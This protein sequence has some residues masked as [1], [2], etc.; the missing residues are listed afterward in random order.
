[1]ENII[2]SLGGDELEKSLM[3]SALVFGFNKEAHQNRPQLLRHAI[4]SIV[5]SLGITD[6]EKIRKEFKVRFNKTVAIE[7]IQKHLK[8]LVK[9]KYLTKKGDNYELAS[10]KRS[11]LKATEDALSASTARL[12]DEIYARSTEGKTSSRLPTAD[13]KKKIK[14]AILFYFRL[15][16]AEY[17]DSKKKTETTPDTI[18]RYIKSGLDEDLAN[19]VLL[20]LAYTLKEPTADQ[21]ETLNEWAKI[22]IFTQVAQLDPIL[23]SFEATQFKNKEFILDTEVVLH[24]LTQYTAYSE[25]YRDMVKT[26]L[27]CG[28][29][30]IIPEAI[31]KEVVKHAQ[32]SRKCFHYFK[33]T[34]GYIDDAITETII[35]N[36]FVEDFFKSKDEYAG[37][38]VYFDNYYDP[39]DPHERIIDLLDSLFKG[40]CYEDKRL[41][42][43]EY[44]F[45]TPEQEELFIEDILKE[46]ETTVKG[47]RRSAEDNRSIA[48]T[49]ASIYLGI[50]QILEDVKKRDPQAAANKYLPNSLYFVTTS[51]RADKVAKRM[52][53][54]HG[55][56][57]S[58][59]ILISILSV[60]G[61]TAGEKNNYLNLFEN[62]FLVN[63]AKENWD[64]MKKLVDFGLTLKGANPF[65]LKK[66]LERTVNQWLSTHDAEAMENVIEKAKE[67]GVSPKEQALSLYKETKQE[68]ERLKKE[69]EEQRNTIQRLTKER[70][71]DK[72]LAGIKGKKK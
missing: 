38:D 20:A 71:K 60:I 15:F 36:V 46:T 57:T 52:G 51:T 6:A 30:V 66:R 34:L 16:G 24:C 18:V 41:E 48:E 42:R 2:D 10:S 53:I 61:Q 62:P 5:I 7:T 8:T 26:L 56:I 14:T 4:S 40:L 1:M 32:S 17:F 65:A 69:N 45:V 70:R 23:S 33:D 47:K 27:G 29:K 64:C 35:P 19:N 54:G 63:V 72:Y 50:S 25:P 11:E 13:I 9:N 28:C 55:V 39:D 44:T 22:Y 12:I 68:N 31:L 67:I 21:R 37:F 59:N 49:D 3:K 43:R 58:P